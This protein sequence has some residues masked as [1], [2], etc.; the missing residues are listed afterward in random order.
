[1]TMS[2]LSV[3]GLRVTARPADLEVVRSLLNQRP[4]V[5][6]HATDPATGRLIVTLECPT[7]GDHQLGLRGIR[8]VE[9]VLAAD[10]VMHYRDPDPHVPS[11]VT[12]GA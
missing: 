7:I 5:E 9:G 1:M 3:S 12:E 10:L 6:V 8:A 2:N 4:G 11:A